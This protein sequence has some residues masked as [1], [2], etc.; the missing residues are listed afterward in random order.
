MSQGT[1]IWFESTMATFKHGPIEGY[2]V[3]VQDEEQ[4]LPQL[5]TRFVASKSG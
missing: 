3:E 5:P 1:P 2:A 4:A